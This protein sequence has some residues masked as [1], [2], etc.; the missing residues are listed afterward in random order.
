VTDSSSLGRPALLPESEL[1]AKRR[2]QYS[3]SSER[4][5]V[6]NAR[7]IV[8]KNS[9][10]GINYYAVACRNTAKLLQPRFR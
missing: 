9:S 6:V 1:P 3:V 7:V 2:A 4:R 10:V 5:R 8:N